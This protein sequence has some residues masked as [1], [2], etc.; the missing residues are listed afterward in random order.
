MAKFN[1]QNVPRK[2][3]TVKKL[4]KARDD[5]VIVNA[6]LGTAEVWMAMALS[7]DPFL[8]SAFESK[9]NFHSYIAK[10]VFNLNCPV[11]EIEHKYK[12]E[13][14]ASKTITF[15]ILYGAT[16]F[17]LWKEISALGVKVSLKECEQMIVD[18]F[19]KASVLK[20]WMEEQESTLRRTGKLLYAQG[21]I[22]NIP[23]VF[24][25][26][27]GV[28]EH[29]I[30]SGI[31]TLFQGTASDIMLMGFTDFMKEYIIANNW[32]KQDLVRPFTIVHDSLASEVHKSVLSEYREGLKECLQRHRY[33]V[34]NEV[35]SVV[36]VDFEIGAN[37]A[38]V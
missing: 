11:E 8:M 25:N 23:D 14:Q 2:D 10:G 24:S 32:I 4:F 36:P 3:K 13:R 20:D 29:A 19:N 33:F 21:R 27:S 6:D 30:R 1:F 5:Y 7:L 22:R 34:P 18:Y 16:A 37:W 38:F 17:R 26:N 12:E 15:G 35:K 9:L 28:A 31:N